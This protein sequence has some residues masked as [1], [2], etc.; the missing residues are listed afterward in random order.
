VAS[1]R[2]R[3]AA[4]ERLIP[5]VSL[6]AQWIAKALSPGPYSHR[7]LQE[8]RSNNLGGATIGPGRSVPQIPVPSGYSLVSQRVH[9]LTVDE[10][11]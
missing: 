4:C 10:P 11:W 9:S 7:V 2:E 8:R 5:F 1:L 3:A 6:L